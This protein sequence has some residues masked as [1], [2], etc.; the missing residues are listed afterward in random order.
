VETHDHR[1][2]FSAKATVF[3]FLYDSLVLQATTDTVFGAYNY[4][5]DPLLQTNFLKSAEYSG[6][7]SQTISEALRA[8]HAY[9]QTG[10]NALVEDKIF[11]AAPVLQG[12]L[13]D[14]HGD[15]QV[16]D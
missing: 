8:Y 7:L 13:N 10:M 16:R 1:I 5:S 15:A 9:L 6:A 2:S 12:I 14:V 11:P 3:N 4:I